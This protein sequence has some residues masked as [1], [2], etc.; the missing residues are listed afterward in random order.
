MASPGYFPAVAFCGFEP[1]LIKPPLPFSPPSQRR[2]GSDIPQG[3]TRI[4]VTTAP[5]RPVAER[6]LLRFAY[7]GQPVAIDTAVARAARI[8]D[9]IHNRCPELTRADLLLVVRVLGEAERAPS[10]KPASRKSRTQRAATAL[11]RGRRCPP[12]SS[13]AR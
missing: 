12:T 2:R 10:R 11:V 13:A 7:Y 8:L 6:R 1:P 4:V 9:R 5:K 3:R